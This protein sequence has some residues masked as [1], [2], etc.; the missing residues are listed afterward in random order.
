MHQ[1][2]RTKGIV[3]LKKDSGEADQIFVL[4]TQDFGRIEV[5]GKAIRK[6]T[7]KLKSNIDVFY[8]IEVEFIQGKSKKILTDAV[9]IDK[10][11]SLRKNFKKLVCVSQIA[12][13]VSALANKEQIDGNVWELLL[14]TFKAIENLVIENSLEILKHYFLWNF[15]SLLGYSPE[16]FVCSV[17]S[18]KLLPQ[19]FFLS[20]HHGG[21]VCWECCNKMQK[22]NQQFIFSEISV[23]AVKLVRFL[24]N[25][26]IEMSQRLS[27]CGNDLH[28]LTRVSDAYFNFLIGG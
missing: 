14:K 26:P 10:F 7:S 21:V 20:P 6:I 25:Q 13:A 11:L 1:H 22:Q 16:L 3:L 18:Q 19:T 28:E 17:C 15:F 27:F 24:I 4:Y 12:K 23:N 9:V 2:Y 8:F 5:V